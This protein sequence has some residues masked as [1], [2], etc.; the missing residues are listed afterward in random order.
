[1]SP[2]SVQNPPGTNPVSPSGG[3]GLTGAY[4]GNPAEQMLKSPHV[5]PNPFDNTLLI[6]ATPQ[7]YE[8]I[9]NLLRQLDVA[10]RQVLI[11]AKIYEVDLTN[12]LKY[13]MSSTLEKA[14]A[15]ST[16][17]VGLAD[18]TGLG[19]TTGFLATHAKQVLLAIEASE[20]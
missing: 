5:I 17:L 18:A 8:Q 15:H 9:T 3:V 7:E 11:D 1:N 16:S 13:G 14:G 6:Q 19:L 10:P 4:L 20:G 12:A 2:L